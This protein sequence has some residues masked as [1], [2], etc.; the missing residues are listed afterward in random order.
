MSDHVAGVT[1]ETWVAAPDAA[2]P[3]ADLAPGT[4]AGSTA[5][6]DLKVVGLH[7]VPVRVTAVHHAGVRPV[8]TVVAGEREVRC[9]AAHPLL[10]RVLVDGRPRL[11]WMAAHE[12]RPGDL[13]AR[14]EP[15]P[16]SKTAL[17]SESA[18][19]GRT[20]PARDVPG[21]PDVG[22]FGWAPVELV[23]ATGEEP[24]YGLH[25]DAADHAFVTDGFVSRTTGFG[26]ARVERIS[27]P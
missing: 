2:V 10:S 16:V 1:G 19:T 20:D 8:L 5:E 25:L 23:V 22:F 12:L 24:V 21:A 11:V 15:A 14:V 9:T 7:G 6:V 26:P 18:I 4:R 13:I 3:V 27:A 17:R